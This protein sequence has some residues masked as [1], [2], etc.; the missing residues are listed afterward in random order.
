MASI[1]NSTNP[2][3]R[4]RNQWF[5]L[6]KLVASF[7][8]IVLHIGSFVTHDTTGWGYYLGWYSV[9]F[10]ITVSTWLF[11]TSRDSLVRGVFVRK[12]KRLLLPFLVWSA[13]GFLLHREVWTWQNIIKQLVTGTAVNAPLYYLPL[14]ALI[15][16]GVYFVQ[17]RI[18]RGSGIYFIYI[19]LI[20]L[21]EFG[22]LEKY[23]TYY[24]GPLAFFVCKV[25]ELSKYSA[26][27]LYLTGQPKGDIHQSRVRLVLALTMF[28]VNLSF[29]KL[30]AAPVG[31]VG[32]AQLVIVMLLVE[33]ASAAPS[34]PSAIG[35]LVAPLQKYTFGIYALHFLVVERLTSAVPLVTPLLVFLGCAGVCLLIDRASHGRLAWLVR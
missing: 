15:L 18:P 1:D 28:V 14:L 34:F 30:T 29:D 17:Q 20:L 33:A 9:P 21:A 5:D 12:M 25:I 19:V 26:G 24:L 23:L 6:I 8:V 11:V 22:G 3:E 31:Y 2:P 32:A 7:F 4:Q 13:I 16:S 27:V 10:F 35:N